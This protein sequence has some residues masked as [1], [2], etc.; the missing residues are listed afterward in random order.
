MIDGKTY[1]VYIL[2]SKRNGTLYTG[3]TNS[4]ERRVYEHKHDVNEGFTKR[5]G[6]HRLVYYECTSDVYA[7]IQRE[8]Q[9]KKW[10][11]KWKLELIEEHNPEWTD[12]CSEE[13]TVL[14]MPRE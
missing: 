5:Y 3:M 8:K 13:G 12:L 9:I 1:F 7:A 10:R 11:R 6:V 14:P 2:A 4:L